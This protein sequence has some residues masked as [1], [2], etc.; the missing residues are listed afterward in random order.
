MLTGTPRALMREP[1]A[2]AFQIVHWIC[3]SRRH[4]LNAAQNPFP[5]RRPLAWRDR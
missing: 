4:H 5:I 2:N 3:A 1:K